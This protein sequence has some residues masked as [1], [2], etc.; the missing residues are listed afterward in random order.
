MSGIGIDDL[1]A[2]FTAKQHGLVA[3]WQLVGAGVT[4]RHIH[5]RVASG[6]LVTVHVAVYRLRGVPFTQ[7]LRWLAGVL[8]AGPDSWLSHRAAGSLHGFDLRYPKAEV[9]IAHERECDIDGVVAHRTRRRHD[10]I[11]VR[12]I[13]VT[14]RARTI[15]DCAAVVPFG[16][17]ETMVQDAVAANLVKQEALYAILDRRGGRG[18]TGVT[19]TR[20]ALSSGLVDEK[21]QRKLELLL[22][23]IIAGARVPPPV[24]QHELVC[25]DGRV[26]VLDNA[27]PER[28]LAVEA[29]GMRWHG[30]AH[31]ARKDR[32]RRRAIVATG[33]DHYDYGWSEATETP[34]VVASE[35]ERFWAGS[36]TQS[37]REPAQNAEAA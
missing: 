31:R 1:I 20:R 26:V 23:R 3:R 24:R 19:A 22:A 25:S 35:I 17:F 28:K 37:V 2:G 12:G 10:V 18:V 30:N 21:I 9:T 15:L 11:T 8:A 5:V 4:D 33:W 29:V 14:T 16:A 6:A 36:R 27:W 34:D 7:E 32:A 13:A